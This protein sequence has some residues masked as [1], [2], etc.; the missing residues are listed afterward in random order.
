MT[1]HPHYAQNIRGAGDCSNMISQ[2]AVCTGVT[3]HI[4]NACWAGKLDR[5]LAT[6]HWKTLL[7]YGCP[8]QHAALICDVCSS[9]VPPTGLLVL[10]KLVCNMSTRS[11]T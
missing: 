3:S 9:Q 10:Q 2:S 6:A 7:N 1:W 4:R 5:Q 11:K 8:Y